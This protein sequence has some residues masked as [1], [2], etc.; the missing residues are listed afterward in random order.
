MTW[1]EV[2]SDAVKIGLGAIIGGLLALISARQT[3]RHRV[4]EEYSRRR[5]DHLEKVMAE[6]DTIS[7]SIMSHAVAIY[8]E[9]KGDPKIDE[10]LKKVQENRVTT[11]KSLEESQRELNPLEARV[12]LMGFDQTA[13]SI[14]AFRVAA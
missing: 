2:A 3:H 13:K 1:I 9:S 5:R 11:G 14:E 10:A 6:F 12:A 7:L 8:K 4:A